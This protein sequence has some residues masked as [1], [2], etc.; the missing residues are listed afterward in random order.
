MLFFY[1]VPVPGYKFRRRRVFGVR[2]FCPIEVT[3]PDEHAASQLNFI[4]EHFE[5]IGLYKKT[6]ISAYIPPIIPLLPSFHF[7]PFP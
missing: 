1:M 4:F 6:A 2:A 5:E 7:I 3:V